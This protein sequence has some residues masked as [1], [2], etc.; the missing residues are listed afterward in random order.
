MSAHKNFQFYT[1]WGSQYETTN[2][3]LLSRSK[4]GNV[5]YFVIENKETVMCENK[6]D[7]LFLLDK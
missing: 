1:I 6:Q 4:F 2:F 5:I 3:V 7:V